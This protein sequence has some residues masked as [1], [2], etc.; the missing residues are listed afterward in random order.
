MLYCNIAGLSTVYL[1]A[2]RQGN[3]DEKQAMDVAHVNSNTSFHTLSQWLV[4][5][6]GNH[7]FTTKYQIFR[8]LLAFRHRVLNLEVSPE[9]NI[10][11][12]TNITLAL[13][14]DLINTVHIPQKGDVWNK[15]VAFDALSRCK[16]AIGIQRALGSSFFTT[17][18]ISPSNQ[19]WFHWLESSSE[20]NM[21]S[22]FRFH[23]ALRD[24]F[25]AMLATAGPLQE[26]LHHSKLK[27]R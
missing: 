8:H 7:T 1:S 19:Q 23:A 25:E 15:F 3:R 18:A 22:A 27:V 24:E 6:I 13:L 12:Y 10:R 26:T 17:C 4:T 21:D 14:D 5:T 20:A 11:F 2:D 9:E 16:D